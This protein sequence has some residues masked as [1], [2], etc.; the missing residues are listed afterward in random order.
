MTDHPYI[1]LADTAYWKRS[2]ATLNTA[3]VDPVVTFPFRITPEQRIATAGSCFAQHL[4]TRLQKASFNYFVTEQAP[5]FFPE[6]L[7]R[8]FGYGVFTARYGNIYTTRQLVQLFKRAYAQVTA[9]EDY[10]LEED[11]N[12]IDPFRPRIQ[13]G[14]FAS[15][16]EYWIDRQQ[17]Y[18]AVRA[19]FEELDIF[20]FTLGLTEGWQ[21][22]EDGMVYPLCP[23]VAGGTFDADKYQF[24]NFGVEETTSDLLEFIDL[25]HGVNPDARVILTVSP[26]PLI[27]TYEPQHVL[28]STTY[29]KSVLRVSCGQIVKAR[30][31][32]AYFPSYEIIT[33]SYTRGKYTRGK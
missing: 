27:A 16:E 23:G 1:H 5:L 31:H 28:T 14:G 19:A 13:E 20:V 3:D 24:V 25:L 8:S 22:R 29:S 2:I 33:G 9:K 17:H 30:K 10:W 21:S 12:Y 4:S 32:V 15:E 7:A 26:V 11:N 18:Q 6:E